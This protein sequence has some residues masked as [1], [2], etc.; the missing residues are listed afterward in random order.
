METDITR[1]S[2]DDICCNNAGSGQKAPRKNRVIYRLAHA[3]LHQRQR[4]NG[5]RV[6]VSDHAHVPTAR[7]LRTGKGQAAGIGENTIIGNAV[8]G[9]AVK[10]V[11]DGA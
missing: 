9:Q 7:Q 4:A 6:E 10:R 2:N 11:V 5:G 1:V 3:Q 8:Y